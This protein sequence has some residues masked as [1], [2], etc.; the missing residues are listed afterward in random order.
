MSIAGAT[1]READLPRAWYWVEDIA[2]DG[3]RLL[4]RTARG[5]GRVYEVETATGAS[6]QVWQAPPRATDPGV[7]LRY[8]GADRVIALV[9]P[10]PH[11]AWDPGP[12]PQGALHV[13]ARGAGGFTLA[14][15]DA[16][17][18]AGP[19]GSTFREALGRFW[20]GGTPQRFEFQVGDGAVGLRA[21]AA[22]T[23]SP[24][25]RPSAR[26]IPPCGRRDRRVV[27]D[28]VETMVQD[29]RDLSA[30]GFGLPGHVERRFP[31][32]SIAASSRAGSRGCGAP[33]AATRC[34]AQRWRTKPGTDLRPGA[35]RPGGRMTGP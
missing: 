19:T 6:A 18:A 29:A 4:L 3:N 20:V 35:P 33:P 31:R 24:R 15:S 17:M 7:R 10:P 13:L 5:D 11:N 30:P 16:R 28:H 26:R 21:R 34:R 23:P 32:T 12:P 14:L 27:A 9:P 25:T 2:A 8:A 22:S 1:P